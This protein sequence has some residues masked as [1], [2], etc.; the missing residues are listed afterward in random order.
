MSGWGMRATRADNA[1]E[2]ILIFTIRDCKVTNI[3]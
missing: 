2:F 3:L 1:A